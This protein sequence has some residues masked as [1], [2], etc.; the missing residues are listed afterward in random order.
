[1]LPTG[2]EKNEEDP[3]ETPMGREEETFEEAIDPAD[4]A[5]LGFDDE[6]GEDDDE[7]EEEEG[8]DS[9]GETSPE[10]SKAAPKAKKSAKKLEDDED[11][12]PEFPDTPV[13]SKKVML[14]AME[15]AFSGEDNV[16]EGLLEKY[17]DHARFML[18]TNREMN[19]TS[20]LDPK[21]IA[22][23]HYLDSWRLTKLLPLMAKTVLDLGSGGGLPGIPLAIAEPELSMVLCEARLQKARYLEKAV[24][25]IGLT[26]ARVVAQRAEEWLVDE[27][28]NM[29]I[30]REVSSVRENIRTLR[31]V[32]HS[33]RDVV[34]LKGN[35]WS[36]ELRAAEREAER[37]GFRLDTVW[38]H[39]LPG[40]MG[41]R[42]VL[43][44]RAPGGM[45]R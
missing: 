27:K 39:D 43:V 34:M 42:V 14:N 30:I 12:E 26:N 8:D 23:K 18:K 31:K 22:A 13:P 20:I 7:E 36:R 16:P 35:S 11:E 44:Y 37:L 1:M 29:V 9:D 24:K 33:M 6:E 21:E 19:L 28:V 2:Q 15:W 17:A 5:D 38:E 4:L 10:D 3:D 40:E 41:H 45:G 25:E 32:R